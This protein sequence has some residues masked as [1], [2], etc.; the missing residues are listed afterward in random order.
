[1]RGAQTGKRMMH[2]TRRVQTPREAQSDSKLNLA[3][4]A[5]D[6]NRQL[7]ILSVAEAGQAYPSFS[8]NPENGA[9]SDNTF[10]NARIG[11]EYHFQHEVIGVFD[12]NNNNH[13]TNLV[14]AARSYEKF[15]R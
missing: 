2:T 15:R 10:S 4:L 13:L 8:V 1:M 6:H 12:R 14:G 7:I 3:V 9:W 11:E 5:H